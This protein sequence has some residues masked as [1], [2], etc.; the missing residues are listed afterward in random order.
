MSISLWFFGIPTA[1]TYTLGLYPEGGQAYSATN[2]PVYRGEPIEPMSFLTRLGNL[3][4][5]PN[6]IASIIAIVAASIGIAALTGFSSMY[7][8]PLIMLVFLF[9]YIAMPLSAGVLGTTCQ[10]ETAPSNCVEQQGL[11]S[12]IYYPLLLVFNI[13]T[14]LACISFIRGGV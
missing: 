8:I 12:I 5:N 14:V 4:S 2:S 3:F 6:G 1:L 10:S 9:N 7:F 13:M 11:P